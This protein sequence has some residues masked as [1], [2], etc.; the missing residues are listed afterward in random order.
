MKSQYIDTSY[1]N[2]HHRVITSLK[3]IR[4]PNLREGWFEFGHRPLETVGPRHLLPHEK[5][6][7][8]NRGRSH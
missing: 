7:H 1:Y 5:T 3:V 4:A 8:A 6:L 2:E